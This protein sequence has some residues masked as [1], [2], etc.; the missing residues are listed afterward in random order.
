MHPAPKIIILPRQWAPIILQW[1]FTSVGPQKHN[2]PINQ[3]SL[4]CFPSSI[5]WYIYISYISIIYIYISIVGCVS[6]RYPMMYPWDSALAF[7]TSGGISSSWT[8]RHLDGMKPA[9]LDGHLH[10][11]DALAGGL[12][13]GRGHG[14]PLLQ[15]AKIAWKLGPGNFTANMVW[16]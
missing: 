1:K 13:F 16:K 9:I 4:H 15:L 14:T 8:T 10:V 5:P 6:H 7:F 3:G 12:C 2:A 11:A